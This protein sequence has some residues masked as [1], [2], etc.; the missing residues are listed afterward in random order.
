MHRLVAV[1]AATLVAAA[2][3][4]ASTTTNTYTTVGCGFIFPANTFVVPAGVTSVDLEVN[5]ARGGG[6][7]NGG[8]GATLTR[9]NVSVT[10]GESLYACV[11][12]GPGTGGGSGAQKGGDGGGGSLVT[13]WTN[14]GG[15]LVTAGGGGG[16]TATILG[17]D[18][19]TTF[20]AGFA[21]H[22]SV[23]APGGLGGDPTTFGTGGTSLLDPLLSGSDGDMFGG[24]NGGWTWGYLGGG[25]GGG[26]AYG[27][28][29]GA[30]GDPADDGGGGGGGSSS[31]S[32]GSCT[33]ALN[34]GGA[35]V[36]I[37]YVN[38]PVP[39]T[40][41][42]SAP[43][44]RVGE[45]VTWKA[46]V[47]PA[48]SG[49]TV[50]FTSGG[51]PL[52]TGVLV[53]TTTGVAECLAPAPS[54]GGAWSVQAAF[55]GSGDFVTSNTTKAIQMTA[56]STVRVTASPVVR[57]ADLVLKAQV[58]PASASGT[59]T[60]AVD[61]ATACADVAVD[62]DGA[63]SCNAGPRASGTHKVSASYSGGAGHDPASDSSTASVLEGR[64]AL[65]AADFDTVLIGDSAT[66]ALTLQNTGDVPLTIASVRADGPFVATAGTCATLAP[67]A[68]CALS[69][70]F[71]PAA[72]PMVS[73]TVTV[74]ADHGVAVTAG[75]SGLGIKAPKPAVL[76]P[77]TGKTTTIIKGRVAVTTTCPEGGGACKV[78]TS[79]ALNKGEIKGV[80][81]KVSRRYL[82][83][84]K[85]VVIAP[86]TSKT[87]T[88]KVTK[89]F[90]R[91]AKRH[92]TTKFTATYRLVTTLPSG[93]RLVSTQQVKLKL[94]P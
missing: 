77:L 44:A 18:A 81:A 32:I 61:G 27:G 25:G 9:T 90:L 79:I 49:G 37:S 24:G 66:R 68:T 80:A 19:G 69:V 48:P 33:G 21:G 94:V 88:I 31:C 78:T 8:Y 56:P 4:Q 28:G 14:M 76:A 22:G 34:P 75:L 87:V 64:L 46:V 82:G 86:G 60:F 40:T 59:V 84:V 72:E 10:P 47:A 57:G 7:G 2:P 5:G 52:C 51:S 83:K 91:S 20:F 50:D 30:G 13:R 58:T 12:F 16:G 35:S 41:V 54:Q 74:A 63:A 1:A 62:G 85:D 45:T 92:G 23:T 67:G 70:R 89:R 38:P 65:S 55:S 26:G 93:E 36:R 42:L 71:T 17:G 15:S 6:G 3:A 29:G 53:D 39:T 73:G 11:G 43:N